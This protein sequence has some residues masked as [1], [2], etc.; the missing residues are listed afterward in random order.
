MHDWNLDKDE[1]TQER[2]SMTHNLRQ[3][4]ARI[5]ADVY[6]SPLGALLPPKKTSTLS[7]L[8]LRGLEVLEAEKRPVNVFAVPVPPEL[9]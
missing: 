2:V 5:E 4:V 1:A 6:N 8:I 9:R 7:Y 3:R